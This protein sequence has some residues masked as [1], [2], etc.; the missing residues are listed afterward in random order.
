M[1]DLAVLTPSFEGDA[2]LFADLHASVLANTARSVVHHVVVPPTDA[3][4]FRAYAGPRCRVWTH[5]DLL[6][7]RFLPI[8]RA[9][10]L[11]FN[12]RRPW[13]PVRGWIVQQLMKMA[14]T[15]AIDARVVLIA[16][17]D[18]ALVRFAAADEFMHN[19]RLWHYRRECGIT[20]GMKR[21]VLWHN[22]ARNLL[23]LDGVVVPPLHDYVSPICAWDP[24]VVRSLLEHIADATGRNWIDAVASR[25]HVSEFVVYGVFV[26]HVLGGM[27]PR[28]APL[29][30]NYYGRVPLSQTDALAFADLMP[31]SAIGAM[32][33]SHSRTSAVVRRE[34]FGRCREIAERVSCAQSRRS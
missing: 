12:V 25:L 22:V 6:P 8:P 19:G 28:D 29:S 11:A 31:P 26:D 7:R 34:A 24:V 3:H 9:S 30:H 4:V 27:P 18:S 16:D 20:A 14:G 1:E 13:P 5:R 17:S 21:H 23:G 33:S 32:I 15:A 2:S 10:G